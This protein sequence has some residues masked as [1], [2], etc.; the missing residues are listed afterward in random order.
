MRACDLHPQEEDMT[1]DLLKGLAE[2]ISTLRY[3]ILFFR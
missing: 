2:V 1:L 3:G